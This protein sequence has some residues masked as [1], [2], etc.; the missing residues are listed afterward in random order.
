MDNF[1]QQVKLATLLPEIAK[2]IDKMVQDSGLPPQP[3]SL[4]TWG[5]HRCQYISNVDRA[6]SRL[7]MR[8]TLDRWDEEQAPAPSQFSS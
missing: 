3:W 4:Y 8:E 1:A 7:A 2:A 6:Q 5:G